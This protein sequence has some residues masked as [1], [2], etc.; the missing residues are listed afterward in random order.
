[1]SNDRVPVEVL[2]DRAKQHGDEPWLVQP[3]NG[4]PTVY[5]W[6]QAAEQV[7]RMAAAL[8]DMGLDPGSRIAIS[9]VNT[10]HWLMADL[11][12][13]LAGHV[14]VGLY[15]KQSPEHVTYILEHSEAKVAFI[16]PMPD[17]DD[18]MGAVPDG[19]KT[20]AFTYDGLPKCDAQ[21][22][23]LAERH[24]PITEYS[25]PDRDELMT[26]V[27]TS[28]ST[29]KPKAVM[30]T[31]GNIAFAIAGFV[32]ALPPGDDERLFSYL[33]LAHI[34]E[35]IAVGLVSIAYRGELHFLE[36][37][38]KLADQLAEVMPTRF[39]GVPLVFGRVQKGIL[40]KVPQDK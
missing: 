33:P 16:G 11:A 21:W 26:L 38:D 3:V 19:V 40:Q 27:Y 39:F 17:A 7:G 23:A 32:E 10:A 1:M 6:S 25:P 31:F 12:I 2:L 15:P 30:L 24:A 20:I 34:F 18:F 14:S 28:G 22:D 5:T 36:S 8:R 4:E 9:G 29:G 35:R 13:A 37:A